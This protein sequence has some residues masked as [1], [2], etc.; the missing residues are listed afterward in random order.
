M[1]T[2][3]FEILAYEETP[4]G[5]LCLRRRELL[6]SPGEF[7]TEITLD[8]EFLMSSYHT[9]SERVLASIALEMHR[10]SEISVLIGGLGLGYTAHEI[11]KSKNIARVEVIE[12]LPQVIEWLKK[13]LLPLSDELNQDT[14]LS[15]P[16][17]DVYAF[18]SR[19][20]ESLYDLI[21]IDVDHSPD[22]QLGSKND[23]FYTEAGLTLA[24]AHLAPDGILAV[25]SY[26]ESSNF[27]KSLGAVF[28]TTRIEPVKFE[29]DLIEEECTDWLF[30]AR[31][32]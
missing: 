13:G 11:L 15:T 28:A 9:L 1:N 8:H 14:R 26:A 6:S 18:L 31:N 12:F 20:P 17:G 22:D 19:P 4:L 16:H 5:I 2:P 27:S 23:Q 24:K 32:N 3:H 21:V 7:V 10:G 25:W 30:F 29:N